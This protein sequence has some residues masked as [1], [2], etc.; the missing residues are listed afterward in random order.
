MFDGFWRALRPGGVVIMEGYGV[1][2]L[3]YTSGGPK[4]L[5]NL[6]TPQILSDA[7]VGW[8]I[9]PLS[10][11]D[12]LLDEGPKHRGMAALVDLVARKPD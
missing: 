9:L 10:E 4:E 3:Q 12:A 1:R 8:K 5:E 11:Y 2:Q 7:L 6:Y